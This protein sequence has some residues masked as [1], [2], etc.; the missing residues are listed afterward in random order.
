M[1]D[2]APIML[3]LLPGGRIDAPGEPADPATWTMSGDTLEFRRPDPAAPGSELID[4]CTVSAGRRS[5]SGRNDAGEHIHGR[6][7]VIGWWEHRVGDGPATMIRL[8]P[9]HKIND[10]DG[11][12]TWTADGDTLELRWPTPAAPG[13]AW[14]DTLQLSPDRSAYAG[15]NQIGLT[16]RGW[17]VASE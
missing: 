4:R 2:K 3:H 10:P 17:Q 14:I 9:N 15:R 8:L 7:A 16:L 13:G 11:A 12:A 5:Y 1:A 6:L